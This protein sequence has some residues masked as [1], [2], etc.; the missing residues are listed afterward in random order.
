VAIDVYREWLKIESPERPPD[1]YT[2]LGLNRFEDDRAAIQKNYRDR[3]VFVRRYA[4]GKFS[5]ESQDLLDELA[6]AML[7]L[8]D[9]ARKND[10][11]RKL[12]RKTKRPPLEK[13][14]MGRILVDDGIISAEQCRV[15]QTL[16]DELQIDLRQALVQKEFVSWEEA[17]RALAQ[18]HNL[19]YMDLTG[20]NVS[21]ELIQK[22]PADIALRENLFPLLVDD[23]NLLVAMTHESNLETLDVLRFRTGMPVRAILCSP[24][25]IRSLV[26]KHYGQAQAAG[27]KSKQAEPDEDAPKEEFS[28]AGWLW[29][30]V[31]W[32]GPVLALAG[33]A[34]GY[35]IGGLMKSEVLGAVSGCIVGIVL[36]VLLLFT[37][38]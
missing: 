38:K 7:T 28:F 31:K 14:P 21:P 33:L 3:S 18:Q 13:R 29:R 34:V 23:G 25:G 6:R 15:A 11:D 1:L 2:L 35:F 26:Q 37:S 9:P 30:N 12:G 4:T 24:P 16:A 36:L 19:P 20:Q 27:T 10:Y 5:K 8:T 17:T 22:V 32:L